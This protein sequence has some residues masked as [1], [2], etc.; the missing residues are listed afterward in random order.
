MASRAVMDAVEARVAAYWAART[1]IFGTNQQGSVPNDGSPFLQIEFPVADEEQITIG[2][3][4]ANV[5]RETGAFRVVLSAPIGAGRDPYADWMDGL[6]AFVRGKQFGAVNT[7]APSPVATNDQ[8]DDGAYFL[9]SFATP[10]Y[11]DLL[12]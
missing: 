11:A 9:L 3:P 7:W 4:G 10:F 2:A 5:F 6:R 12:G 8:S 1:P